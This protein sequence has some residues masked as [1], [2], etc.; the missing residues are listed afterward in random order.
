MTSIRRP[1]SPPCAAS[2]FGLLLLAVV[3][4][5]AVAPASA[6]SPVAGTPLVMPPPAPTQAAAQPPAD[7]WQ[8]Q[9]VGP[10]RS[11]ARTLP[12]TLDGVLLETL[13]YS[14]QVRVFSDL[15][16]IR[17]TAVAEAAA[18][19]DWAAFVESRWDDVS[20]PV[21]NELTT[22]GDPRFSDHNFGGSAG[23]RRR[24]RTGGRIEASQRLGWQDTNSDF[25]IPDQQGT[26]RLSVS[27]TQPLLRGRGRCYNES[28]LVLAS[29]DTT[30]AEHEFS[31]QLQAHL[32]EVVRAYWGLYLERASLV[33]KIAARDRAVELRDQLRRRAQLDTVIAQI[34]RAEAEVAMRD[35]EQLRAAMAVANAETRL[36]TLVGSP[37]WDHT[38][39]CELIPVD[40]PTVH[41]VGLSIDDA[42]AT[43]VRRRPEILQ[44]IAQIKAASIRTNMSRHE[45]LPVLN[46]L[47]EV[48]VS[49]LERE[50]NIGRSLGSQFDEGAPS[51]SIGL[52]YEVPLGNR[53]ARAR[54]TRKRLE[55][56][57]LQ[58]QYETTLD[59][60][61]LEVEAAVREVDTAAAE[62]SARRRQV[63]ASRTQLDYLTKRWRLLPG[64]GSTAS[65]LLENLLDA[66]D[67]LAD[68]EFSLVSSRV[69]H[70]L[71]VVNVKR[72]TGELLQ[73]E[74]VEVGTGCV[75]GLPT[76]F[77]DKQ[78]VRG[79]PLRLGAMP[80]APIDRPAQPAT[81]PVAVAPVE[82]VKATAVEVPLPMMELTAPSEST[83]RPQ[84]GDDAYFPPAESPVESA[85]GSAGRSGVDF[86]ERR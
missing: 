30:V 62:M 13:S 29:V 37:A 64:E 19:W 66:Q 82:T 11:T 22:G 15:P 68:A 52:A 61:G 21:G 34:E 84:I 80:S 63:A 25:F 73:C 1:S 31:R 81:V 43:A 46:L 40:Q 50:G 42:R 69:T 9:I 79:T 60:L 74:A 86:S 33:Q 23:V 51:Y 10:L 77:I 20:E 18:S 8:P 56:R 53:A 38:S 26:S 59:T 83:R 58:A 3:A 36:R 71:A 24:T 67:R 55:L 70:D 4:S 5:T 75:G 14:P 57:Q 47:T 16:H 45:L 17:R 32:V 7:W 76:T 65:L 85:D 54:L 78:P 2:A 72:A 28:L 48:Y 39:G 41:H 35:V 44:A 6:Q 12:V 27:Y 49:G